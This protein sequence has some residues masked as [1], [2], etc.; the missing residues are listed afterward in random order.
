MLFYL[1]SIVRTEL[2]SLWKET[3][4][5]GMAYI[6]EI[7]HSHENVIYATPKFPIIHPICPEKILHNPCF[8]FVLGITAVPRETAKFWGATKVHYEKCGSGI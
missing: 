1:S 4:K 3:H 8:S 7:V 5:K 6:M 2:T